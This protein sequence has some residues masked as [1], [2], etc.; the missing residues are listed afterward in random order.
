MPDD[1]VLPDRR[2]F[3]SAAW[4][5]VDRFAP[6]EIAQV[7][8]H[9]V[10][11]E[12]K[13]NGHSLHEDFDLTPA[14]LGLGDVENVAVADMRF[15]VDQVRG[16]VKHLS[17]MV[18]TTTTVNGLPL[19]GDITLTR[20]HVG[21]GKVENLSAREILDRLTRE[22]DSRWQG[23]SDRL[24]EFAGL[25]PSGGAFIV[26]QDAHW[27]TVGVAGV[28]QL[29]GL[30]QVDNT[31]DALKFLRITRRHDR[32][33]AQHRDVDHVADIQ[34]QDH[35]DLLGRLDGLQSRVD[36]LVTSLSRLVTA[37]GHDPAPGARTKAALADILGELEHGSDVD[38]ETDSG[39]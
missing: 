33:Y 27:A 32:R 11:P 25:G 6:A 15:S 31:P 18:A 20:T 28:R 34:R 3:G 5:N 10:V 22:G 13:I 24:K 19:T 21:L 26:G 1:E 17:Q 37:I 29:L 30:D 16:L 23:R 35:T 9:A 36:S 14:D 4:C 12:R 2:K 8:R 7:A 39:R 38:V